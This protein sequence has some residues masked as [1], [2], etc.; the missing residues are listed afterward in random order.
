MKYLV[1]LAMAFLSI[2]QKL[3]KTRFVITRMTGNPYFPSPNPTLATIATAANNLEAA[4]LK[5]K[6]GGPDDTAAM[7]RKEVA[8]DL[9]MRQ[10]ASYI[11]SVANQNATTAEEV[12]L[13]SGLEVQHKGAYI[14]SPFKAATTRNPGEI[15]VQYKAVPNS[16]FHFQMCTDLS[17]PDWKTISETTRSRILV[18][19]LTPG[20]WYYFRVRVLSKNTPTDW[21]EIISVYLVV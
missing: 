11:E 19:G 5:A 16:V 4:A 18:T 3:I 15:K 17:K 9:L 21:S 7:R 6:T 1:K 10:L 12:I 14:R 13:S 8:L 2:A 20:M